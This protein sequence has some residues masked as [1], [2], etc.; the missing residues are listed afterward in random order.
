MKQVLLFVA[1]CLFAAT[2]A[3][4]KG[5][6]GG[7]GGGGGHS[8]S[9]S[10]GRSMETHSAGS[11]VNSG[12]THSA[13][14]PTSK[15]KVPVTRFTSPSTIAAHHASSTPPYH[16]GLPVSAPG[17]EPPI[18]PGIGSGPSYPSYYYGYY[19][20][21]YNDPFAYNPYYSMW[22]LGF[23]MM[24]S[25]NY[26]YSTSGPSNSD[27]QGYSDNYMED[28]LEG[29]VV[30]AHDT[31]SGAVTLRTNTVY[32]ATTDSGR[33]YDYTF[34]ARD[35]ELAYVSAFNS[36]DKQVKL[37]RLDKNSRK[38]WRVVHEGKLNLYD[39]D[40]RFIYRPED[41]DK[42]SLVAEFN[43]ETKS[44]KSFSGTKSKEQLAEYMNAAY[45]LHLD[46]KNFTWNQLLI[47]LDKLD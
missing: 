40:H 23:S 22:A 35:K 5:H 11:H 10:A 25:P 12:V 30:Y 3:L 21:Y 2:G 14:H 38:L 27:D 9:H 37:V 7:H 20:P 28:D 24:Y 39:D 1:T 46:P 32:L 43:G 13:A 42:M 41:I 31:L 47:Y 19:N 34:R 17:S 6:G 4:A 33:K 36:E 18:N 16:G 8:S 15:T 26:P 45:G 29:F 44:L